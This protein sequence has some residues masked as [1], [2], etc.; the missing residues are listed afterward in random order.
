MSITTIT[1]EKQAVQNNP[2]KETSKTNRK[3]IE[4]QYN[5]MKQINNDVL[6]QFNTTISHITRDTVFI[7][8]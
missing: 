3:P 6:P 1:C 8:N 7:Q 4:Y 2:Q 5:Y